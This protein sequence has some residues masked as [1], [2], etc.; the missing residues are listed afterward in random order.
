MLASPAPRRSTKARMAAASVPGGLL[1]LLHQ[2]AA[3]GLQGVRVEAVGQ[4]LGVDPV[5]DP[6]P[7]D[8]G[9]SLQRGQPGQA[10]VDQQEPD[11]REEQD[12]G[13][14]V[15]DGAVVL[16]R[17]GPGGTLQPG[18]YLVV[19]GKKGLEGSR[20]HRRTPCGPDSA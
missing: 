1:E 19:L 20:L 18:A 7:L 5:L 15:D 17:G 16:G 13:G 10:D 3:L 4:G 2:R 12:Q 6:A 11:Q 8:L 9:V 14:H